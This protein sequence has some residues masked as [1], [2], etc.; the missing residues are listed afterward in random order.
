[1]NKLTFAHI[2][3]AISVLALLFLVLAMWLIKASWLD[4]LFETDNLTSA[5]VNAKS[6]I[7]F[8]DPLITVV[9]EDRIDAEQK[10]K[11][12]VS[13]LDPVLGEPTAKVY[14]IL[15]GSLLDSDMTSYL[16][17][18]ATLDD[19]YGDDVT[20]VWKDNVVT[21]TEVLAA[22]LA[23]CA[24]EYNKFWEF[25]SA[26]N[27]RTDDSEDAMVAVATSLSMDEQT[28]RDCVA[29]SGY[30]GQVTQSQATAANLGVTNGHSVFIN[31]R[32]FTEPVDEATI[33]RHIDE[34]LATF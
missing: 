23:H 3:A 16:G 29:T 22:E 18:I 30:S 21:E 2:F 11:V 28:I 10:T 19:A 15:Y 5:Q 31:D 24:N 14:V 13:T 33:K 26:L 7:V 4:T 27:T 25:A 1:M 34:I 17:M 6:G 32:L 8:D 9:P 20:F 12:F